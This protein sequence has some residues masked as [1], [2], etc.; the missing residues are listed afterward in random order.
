MVALTRLR[1]I[2]DDA[3]A[4]APDGEPPESKLSRCKTAL[5]GEFARLLA[6]EKPETLHARLGE[7][8]ALA[9]E[10]RDRSRAIPD[11]EQRQHF[12]WLR[13]DRG[14]FKPVIGENG[15]LRAPELPAGALSVPLEIVPVLYASIT[16][17]RYELHRRENPAPCDCAAVQASGLKR[18]PQC[19]ELIATGPASDGYH[20]GDGFRC[21]SCGTRWLEAATEDSRGT[22]FW[23]AL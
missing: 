6:E 2:I 11:D 22:P 23:T 13:R 8:S 14:W 21:S 1:V 17:L 15:K 18:K 9:D 7:L 5:A 12:D 16:A 20:T 19:P 4:A 10:C 3:F